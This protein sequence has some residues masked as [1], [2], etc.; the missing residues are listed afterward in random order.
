MGRQLEELDAALRRL[1][2]PLPPG[3]TVLLTADHGMLDVPESQRID[4]SADPALLDGVRHT[5]GE[6]RMVHLHLEPPD[7]EQAAHRAIE[8]WRARFGSRVWVFT[9]DAAI[10]AGLFGDL[11]PRSA[12]ASATYSSLAAMP[13]PCSTCAGSARPPW[14]WWAST[15]H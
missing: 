1:I 14:P 5:A 3:T 11:G 4:F 6:P 2:A 12:A 9:R 7:G 10:A 8:A 15:A 13:W